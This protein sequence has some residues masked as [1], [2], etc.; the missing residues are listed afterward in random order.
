MNDKSK[1]KICFEISE[2]QKE[3]VLKTLPRDFNLSEKLR[4]ALDKVMDE[5][6][7]EE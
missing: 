6:E 4:L 2:E 3:R 5:L 1:P 7:T